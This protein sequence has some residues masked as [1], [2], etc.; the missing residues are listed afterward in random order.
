MRKPV[1]IIDPG[2]GGI[3]PGCRSSLWTEK[4]M[5]LKISLYQRDRFR[6]MSIVTV[7]TR[8]DDRTISPAT[9]ARTVRDSGATICL[10]NHIN[11]GGGEGFEAIHSVHSDG[12]LARQCADAMQE[13]GQKVRRVYDRA[14]AGQPKRDYYFMHRD[15]GKVQTVILEYGFADNQSDVKKLTENWKKYAEAIVRVV[16]LYIGVLYRK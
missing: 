3:D 13:A 12:T 15:T 4:D 16:C 9:R 5:A 7:L 14:T 10:C 6:A 2:H 11:A 1:I 8:D